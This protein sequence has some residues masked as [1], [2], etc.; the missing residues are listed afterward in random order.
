MYTKVDW[1]K[2]NFV[3]HVG[4]INRNRTASVGHKNTHYMHKLRNF[5]KGVI[6]EDSYVDIY[7]ITNIYISS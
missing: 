6:N 4:V 5:V 7:V 2:N 1:G 3:L